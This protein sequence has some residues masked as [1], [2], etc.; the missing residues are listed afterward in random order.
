[1]SSTAIKLLAAF[2]MLIDHIGQFFIGTPVL[3]R[4]LGRISAPLF[5][6]TACIGFHHTR[7]KL[8][9]MKNLYFFSAL[10]S[11]IAFILN[12]LITNPPK[13]FITNNIF[14]TILLIDI[15]IYIIE[16]NKNNKPKQS[17]YILYFIMYNITSLIISNTLL[18]NQSASISSLIGI[19]P[20]I[21]LTE[22]GLVIFLYGVYTY[23]F[24]DNKFNLIILNILV[25][26]TYAFSGQISF[27]YLINVNFQWMMI[28]SLPFIL[29]YNN[30]KGKGYKHFFYIFYPLHIAILYISS[31]FFNLVI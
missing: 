1:M 15:F 22:G 6:F 8:K 9:Y 3:L 2:L 27:D 7:N 23:I 10:I 20:N 30:Q 31:Y 28:F 19:F 21:F 18:L 11:I 26:L 5:L 25:S 16:A 12:S 14:S 17:L 4:Q 24:K 29:I 13:S